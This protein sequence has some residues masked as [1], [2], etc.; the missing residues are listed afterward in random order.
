MA[1]G[2]SRQRLPPVPP[3]QASQRRAL[4]QDPHAKVAVTPAAVGGSPLSLLAA[5]PAEA[6]AAQART[7]QRPHQLQRPQRGRT[8]PSGPATATALV[9]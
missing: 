5:L 9:R 7:S 6:N 1:T 8:S 3:A 4:P 2:G